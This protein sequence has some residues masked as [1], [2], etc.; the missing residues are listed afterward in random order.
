MKNEKVNYHLMEIIEKREL[1]KK[2]QQNFCMNVRLMDCTEEIERGRP[3]N[4]SDSIRMIHLRRSTLYRHLNIVN[5]E[6]QKAAAK[7][8][9]DTVYSLFAK[10]LAID[11]MLYKYEGL[12]LELECE[13][14]ISL[15]QVEEWEEDNMNVSAFF[16]DFDE[17][18]AKTPI[19]AI[20]TFIDKLDEA[21]VELQ[22]G[23]YS[24]VTRVQK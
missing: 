22:G 9:L 18:H 16:S 3:F 8:N 20:N 12:L 13:R 24:D 17:Y 4:V 7:Q 2:Q 6:L 14:A 19:Q 1:L 5:E 23:E 21:L 11:Y 15:S 10:K